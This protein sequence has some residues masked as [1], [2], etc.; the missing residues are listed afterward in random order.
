MVEWGRVVKWE[1]WKRAV[2]LECLEVQQAV[3]RGRSCRLGSQLAPVENCENVGVCQG[4][5]S[6]YLVWAGGRVAS[7]DATGYGVASA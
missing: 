7:S 1:W 3:Q 4:S 5:V 2:S 6:E